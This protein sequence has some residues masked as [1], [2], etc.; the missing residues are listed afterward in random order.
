MSATPIAW[1]AGANP[2]AAVPTLTAT[3]IGGMPVDARLLAWEETSAL[4][5]AA[6]MLAGYFLGVV[7]LWR[8]VGISRDVSMWE[9]MAFFAGMALLVSTLAGPL[10]AWGQWSLAAHMAQQM[11]LLALVPPLLLIGRP[12]TVVAQ[13]LPQP[14]RSHLRR[15]F[16]HGREWAADA[17]VIAAAVHIAVLWFWHHPA[18]ITAALYDWRLHVL[19]H[20]S[21][22]TAGLWLWVTLLRR[23]RDE[24]NGVATALVVIVS[25]M[26]QMGFLGALLTFSGRALYPA[27]SARAAAIGLDPLSDQQLAGLIM[28][29]PAC[30]PYLIGGIWL[31]QRWLRRAHR[32]EAGPDM[33]R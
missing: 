25:V 23:I 11:L 12:V 30:L 15:F 14:W 3:I 32:R 21:F 8:R 16:P 22:L 20:A 24:R 33:Q 7:C 17:I 26:M 2:A 28:W 19:M 4:M 31:L 29:V 27:C 9:A 1:I 10:H 18:A 13:A 6:V 5:L